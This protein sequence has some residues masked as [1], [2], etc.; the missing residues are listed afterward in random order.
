MKKIQWI[1]FL[2]MG[3]LY[4]DPLHN[5]T[6]ALS[7]TQIRGFSSWAS[8]EDF[9]KTSQLLTQKHFNN[10]TAASGTMITLSVSGRYYFGSNIMVDPQNDDVTCIKITASHVTL[11]LRDYT[12]S[13]TRV[14]GATG[15]IG[16]EVA[17]NCSNVRII[18]GVISGMHG[19][20]IKTNTNVTNACIENMLIDNC[21]L[22][23]V[24][25]AAGCNNFK[26]LDCLITRCD[27]SHVDAADGAVGLRVTTSKLVTIERCSFNVNE[28]A[29]AGNAL[30]AYFTSCAGLSLKSCNACSNKAGTTGVVYGL[31]FDGA[32]TNL[33]LEDCKA[34]YNVSQN[35]AV[36][37]ISI[38]G[39]TGSGQLRTCCTDSNTAVG[40]DV[41]GMSF[42]A[43][44][45]NFSIIDCRSCNN[46]TN[47]NSY[48][49]KLAAVQ[50]LYFENCFA[51]AQVTSGA[52]KNAYGFYST[53][54]TANT[55]E[56][57]IAF[58]N[59]AGSHAAAVGAGF[60][61]TGNETFS[62]I[63]SSTSKANNG[64][65]GTGYG[66][67]L[68]SATKCTIKGNELIV[69]TGT[70]NGYGVKDA[71]TSSISY[72]SRNSAYGNGSLSGL[73]VNNYDVNVSPG[74]SSVHFPLVAGYFSDYSNLSKATSF[75]N[76]E[77]IEQAN[78]EALR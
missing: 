62:N 53:G 17:A 72:F 48:G 75:D 67:Y 51:A 4:A 49:F 9:Q 44:S 3:K 11:D 37:G 78:I 7:E 20:G 59:K 6:A 47:E 39:V 54:G 29:T 15:T 2:V 70:A 64:N 22:V 34:N 57:C 12:L 63:I 45:N 69:N 36:Y 33:F 68:H 55:F 66:I 56:R 14:N 31:R 74:D 8:N 40:A 1:L 10:A 41:H 61:L 42:S 65:T 19:I 76:I 28:H 50:N 21:T 52:Q 26:M 77:F 46:T 13:S 27:G 38:E 73:I 43:A 18:N 30:G 60:Y 35:G 24:T 16:I 25:L 71:A 32:T 23:G 58:G 5:E